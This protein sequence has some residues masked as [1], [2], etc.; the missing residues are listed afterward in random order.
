MSV[1]P[2]MT[3]GSGDTTVR[4]A[5]RSRMGIPTERRT[6]KADGASRAVSLTRAAQLSPHPARSVSRM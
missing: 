2:G 6:R 5:P 1:T 3:D 4:W